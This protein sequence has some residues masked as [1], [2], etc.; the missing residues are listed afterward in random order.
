MLPLA[1]LL[2]GGDKAI[3][4][5][6]CGYG[7]PAAEVP[8]GVERFEMFPLIG[9]N[10]TRTPGEHLPGEVA[11]KELSQGFSRHVPGLAAHHVAGGFVGEHEGEV[12]NHPLFIS[13]ALEGRDP[14]RSAVEHAEEKGFAAL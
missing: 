10:H 4:P 11:G 2:E 6:L 3:R 14:P 5:G 12:R 7:E 1:D 13:E 9:V 8:V